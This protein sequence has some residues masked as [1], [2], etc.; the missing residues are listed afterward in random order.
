[1]LFTTFIDFMWFTRKAFYWTIY[2]APT[3]DENLFATT[4]RWDF[5]ITIH[6][7]KIHKFYHFGCQPEVFGCGF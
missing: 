7:K 1:M 2:S 4:I 5:V 3:L 6:D